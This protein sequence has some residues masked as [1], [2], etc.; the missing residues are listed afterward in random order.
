[1]KKILVPI[2]FSESANNALDVAFQISKKSDILIILLTVVELDKFH[3][4]AE[5]GTYISAENDDKFKAHLIHQAGLRLEEIIVAYEANNMLG[6][7]ETGDVVEAIQT[8]IKKE[9]IDLVVMGTHRTSAYEEMLFGSHTEKIIHSIDCPVLTIRNKIDA[10]NAKNIV[11][12][13]V[14]DE[15]AYRVVTQIQTMQNLFDANLHLVYINTPVNFYNSR[16]INEMKEEFVQK[17]QLKNFTFTIYNDFT[18]ETGIAHFS[19]DIDADVIALAAKHFS[20]LFDYTISIHTSD[21]LI[22]KTNRPVLTF[23][24]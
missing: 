3:T 17:N 21:V 9:S 1:M 7:V 20:D 18:V 15:L 6:K 16:K 13:T 23:S 8:Y 24:N 5:D 19:D 4:T 22:D 14:F 10:F 12:A 2:D 11:F